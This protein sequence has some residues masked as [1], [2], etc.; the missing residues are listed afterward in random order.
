MQNGGIPKFLLTMCIEEGERSRSHGLSLSILQAQSLSLGIPLLTIN[1]S[2]TNYRDNFI[3]GIRDLK[4]RDSSITQGV[5]GD[6]D[7]ETNGQWERDACREA[8]VEAYLPLWK[9]ERQSILRE[10]LRTDFKAMIIAIDSTKLNPQYLGR[11][12][13]EKLIKEFEINGIDPC[14]ENGEYHS[15]VFEGPMLKF[16]LCLEQGAIKMQTGYYFLDVKLA[17]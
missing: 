10:F 3:R 8:G 14:G 7:I 6:I 1:T 15:I 2:W 4:E 17:N 5:F 16:P 13:D 11:V 9:M 12:I